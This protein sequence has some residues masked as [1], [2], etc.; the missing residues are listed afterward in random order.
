MSNTNASLLSFAQKHT[1]TYEKHH[2]MP[3]GQL[4]YCDG[5]AG[6]IAVTTNAIRCRCGKWNSKW[7]SNCSQCGEELG[8]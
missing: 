2:R 8:A 4:V 5:S 3:D 7:R 1:S 6:G